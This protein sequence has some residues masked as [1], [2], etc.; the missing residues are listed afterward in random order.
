MKVGFIESHFDTDQYIG[1]EN[2][3]SGCS[4]CSSFAGENEESPIIEKGGAC[5]ENPLKSQASGI[6]DKTQKLINSKESPLSEP[7]TKCNSCSWCKKDLIIVFLLVATILFVL[8]R[9][10][11]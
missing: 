11:K 7:K 1:R 8:F 2:Y 3:Y 4:S 5:N 6:L 10:I 9:K